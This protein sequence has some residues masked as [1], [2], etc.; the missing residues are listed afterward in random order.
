MGQLP[1]M[2]IAS[3]ILTTHKQKKISQLQLAAMIGVTKSTYGQWERGATTPSV[4]TLSR[5]AIELD[6][7][8]EWLAT[9]RGP[10]AFDQDSTH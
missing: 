10:K 3:R 4:E 9:G 5:L 6:V 7:H 1:A 8:F 2:S